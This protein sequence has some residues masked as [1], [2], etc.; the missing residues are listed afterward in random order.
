MKRIA[1]LGNI[2]LS[3]FGLELKRKVMKMYK[4]IKN[5]GME[6]RNKVVIVDLEKEFGYWRDWCRSL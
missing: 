3:G 2:G 5:M 4:G 6:R 1:V